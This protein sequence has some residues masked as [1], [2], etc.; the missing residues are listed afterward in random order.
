MKKIKNFFKNLLF[1]LILIL[2]LSLL[3]KLIDFGGAYVPPIEPIDVTDIILSDNSLY[4]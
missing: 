3:V 4:F 1:I 2:V